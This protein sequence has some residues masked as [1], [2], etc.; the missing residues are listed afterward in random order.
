[1]SFDSSR[2][3]SISGD[4][5]VLVADRA[6]HARVG[7][8][9]GLAAALAAQLELLE[10]DAG[11]LLRRA[12]RELLARQLPD[13]V[14]ELLDLVGDARRSLAE[15]VGVELHALAL[16]PVQHLDQRQ[17]DPL[18]QAAQLEPVDLGLLVLRRAPHRP[19]PRARLGLALGPATTASMPASLDQLV[20]RV[21]PPRGVDQVGGHHR[22][23]CERRG[24]APRRARRAAA[25]RRG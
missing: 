20:E 10:Q 11:E 14:L 17:L 19:A 15:P 9:P 4:D 1:M 12:D 21:A 2:H 5:L 24:S 16:E 23:V 7:R 22:V 18:Q 6:Q 25:R 8:E 13:L 3:F